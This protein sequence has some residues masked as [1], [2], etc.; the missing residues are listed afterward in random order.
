MKD[1]VREGPAKTAIVF[2][3]L[4]AMH[5]LIMQ[6]RHVTYQEIESFLGITANSNCPQKRFILVACRTA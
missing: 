6:N 1:K 4:D 2:K 5:E 3:K